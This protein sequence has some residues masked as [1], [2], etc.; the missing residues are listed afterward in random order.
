MCLTSVG[1]GEIT[2]MIGVPYFA[3]VVSRLVT[4]EERRVARDRGQTSWTRAFAGNAPSVRGVAKR[5]AKRMRSS[6]R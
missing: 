5:M 2:Q 4:M 3:L 1:F 6:S